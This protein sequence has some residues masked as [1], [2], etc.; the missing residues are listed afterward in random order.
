[1]KDNVIYI[2]YRND[3]LKYMVLKISEGDLKIYLKY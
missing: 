1:M 2:F 3:L